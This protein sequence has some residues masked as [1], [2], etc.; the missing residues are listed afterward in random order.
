MII[1]AIGIES[2]GNVWEFDKKCGEYG[3]EA[4]KVQG[5]KVRS[6]L[7]Y[8]YLRDLKSNMCVI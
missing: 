4:V 2:K 3:W 8:I 1:G 7:V 5:N 6:H